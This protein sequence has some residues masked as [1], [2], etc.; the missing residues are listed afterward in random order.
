[1]TDTLTHLSYLIVT[2]SG[3]PVAQRLAQIAERSRW[4]MSDYQ[5]ELTVTADTAPMGT[6]LL[7]SVL[8]ESGSDPFSIRALPA[9][10]WSG[11]RREDEWMDLV[12]QPLV[13]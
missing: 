6:H 2:R 10:P 11:H 3:T 1:M 4:Q 8:L 9:P 5:G 7:L 13:T 12:D